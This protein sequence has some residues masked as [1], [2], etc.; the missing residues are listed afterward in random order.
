MKVLVTGA[1]GFIGSHLVRALL[2]RGHS[3]RAIDNLV[4]GQFWRIEEVLRDIEWMQADLSEPD[5]AQAAVQGVDGVL[6]QAAIPSVSRSLDDP[7]ASNRANVS[8]TIALLQACREAGV[9]RLV[10]AGSSSAYGNTPT[11]PKVETMCPAPMSPYAVSKLAAEHYCQ[12]FARL[13]YI[14]TVCL[15]YFNVFGPRQDPR[16]QYAAVIPKFATAL[17][18]GKP[19]TLNG[20]GTQSRDFTYVENAVQANLRALD[21]PEVSGEVINVGCGE[22]YDLNFLIRELAAILGVEPEVQHLASRPGDV[23]HSLADISKARRLLGYEPTVD[24]QEGVRRTVAWLREE[25]IRR[26]AA[27]AAR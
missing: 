18:E 7:V 22:R 3:V 8:G 25:G 21:A 2:E 10:F 20:D 24:F 12:V 5:A 15:R 6:H 27:A 1:A 23:P 17:L 26:Y 14:E 9:R 4:T 11:L 13:G 19:I 16:S